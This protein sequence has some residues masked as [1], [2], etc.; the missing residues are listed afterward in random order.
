MTSGTD[1]A[2]RRRHA[3]VAGLAY[4]LIIVV[5]ALSVNGVDARL[6]VPGDPAATAGN[7]LAHAALF[8]A[9]TA[10]VLAMYAGVLVLAWALYVVL[11]PVSRGLALLALL[12]RAGEAVLGGASVL[13]SVMLLLL[14]TGGG[15]AAA[16]AP[17][18]LHALVGLFVGARA[19]ALDIVL[20]FVGVGGTIYCWLFLVS[21]CIPWPLAAWGVFSYGSML[22]LAFVSLL[23]PD[24]PATPEAVLYGAGALFELAIGLWLLIRGV[25]PV[26]AA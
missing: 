5:A 21:R 9:G 15:D 26:P 12:F 20:V 16:L 10:G 13:I 22:A 2:S 1:A 18:A 23:W 4:I 19:A 14:V 25:A 24:H 3:R 17:D 7:L 8:R 11:R 6:I